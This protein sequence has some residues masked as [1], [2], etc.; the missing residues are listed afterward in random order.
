[1]AGPAILKPRE[2]IPTSR[3]RGHPAV[4]V[5]VTDLQ[6]TLAGQV[7]DILTPPSV[8]AFDRAVDEIGF[9]ELWRLLSG[10]PWAEPYITHFIALADQRFKNDRSLTAENLLANV[11]GSESL[12]PLGAGTV[13]VLDLNS[14]S[15]FQNHVSQTLRQNLDRH[16]Q[17]VFFA[18]G[19]EFGVSMLQM[20][21]GD[22][23]TFFLEE[24]ADPRMDTERLH[25]FLTR[26]EEI[27]VST[28]I[29]SA[30][31][32]R[33]GLDS[34]LYP[35]GNFTFA[36]GVQAVK[37]GEVVVGT[38]TGPQGSDQGYTAVLGQ[39]W[40]KALKLQ[41]GAGKGC[42]LMDEETVV[43]R[44]SAKGTFDVSVVN[45]KTLEPGV[46]EPYYRGIPL[47]LVHALHARGSLS[48][49]A[50]APQPDLG[51]TAI[52]I[53]M[54]S[55]ENLA[56][57][58]E[59][60]AEVARRILVLLHEPRFR[61]F[62]V[63]KQ[64]ATSLHVLSRKNPQESQNKN[65]IE[66][67]CTLA[68][69]AVQES[70][71]TVQVGVDYAKAMLE[72]AYK[73]CLVRDRASQAIVREARLSHAPGFKDGDILFGGD[74]LTAAGNRLERK[75]VIF[76]SQKGGPIQY[77]KISANT[78]G[79][80][81]GQT[82]IGVGPKCAQLADFVRGKS[83]NVVHL[84]ASGRGY[85]RSALLRYARNESP[86]KSFDFPGVGDG[87]LPHLRG[88]FMQLSLFEIGPNSPDEEVFEAFQ[89][90]LQGPDQW[91][92]DCL[93][94]L[95][96]EGLSH[97]EQDYLSRLAQVLPGTSI[98]FIHTGQITDGSVLELTPLNFE[99]AA[100]LVLEANREFP[101]L[102]AAV[103]EAALQEVCAKP[104]MAHFTLTPR[105]L[106]HAFAPALRMFGG[107]TEFLVS[108]I[109]STG[110]GELGARLRSDKLPPFARQILGILAHVRVPVHVEELW[111][112][113]GFATSGEGVD[114]SSF[115]EALKAL[116]PYLA[117]SEVEGYSVLSE[118]SNSAEE[119]FVP[120]NDEGLSQFLLKNI[121]RSDTRELPAEISE[122]GARTAEAELHHL[123]SLSFANSPYREHTARLVEKLGAF[124]LD[125]KMNTAARR[126][127][128]HYYVQWV[129]GAAE[130]SEK[131][132]QLYMDMA[133]TFLDTR[134]RELLEVV[135]EIYEQL[136]T[137]S[138]NDEQKLEIE[139]RR[140]RLLES[141]GP[142]FD[143]PITD[144]FSVVIASQLDTDAKKRMEW[145]AHLS[146]QHRPLIHK[147]R[148]FDA[149][150][151]PMAQMLLWTLAFSA[152][153]QKVVCFSE[154]PQF[155]G[156]R[157]QLLEEYKQLL[158]RRS[159]IPENL[160][161]FAHEMS[162]R[163]LHM[164]GRVERYLL[165]EID[166]EVPLQEEAKTVLSSIKRPEGNEMRRYGVLAV[167]ARG[168][169][170]Y[171][172]LEA[173]QSREMDGEILEF[174][175]NAMDFELE[176]AL[177]GDKNNRWRAILQQ[178]NAIDL[179][180]RAIAASPEEYE[181]D[182]TI[183]ELIERYMGLARIT[184]ALSSM[185]SLNYRVQ[186]LNQALEMLPENRF[187]V[188]KWTL[189][190]TA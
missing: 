72:T 96:R 167:Q 133:W 61:D 150:G 124:Y 55:L 15:T 73:D 36:T 7:G 94:I 141:K 131:D 20:P 22:Q 47:A 19:K 171:R 110:T 93:L 49:L 59:K 79:D 58:P 159:E 64:D 57:S 104:E 189:E 190:E 82:L 117:F 84:K 37:A 151:L 106:I 186:N 85:G 5:A 81:E 146:N 185:N 45:K 103:V 14:Y 25:A 170:V 175:R 188:R 71:L 187:T 1:M 127:Y 12:R 118:H 52:G 145:A 158:Q 155:N 138:L 113:Y 121:Y 143:E 137:M 160:G 99:E 120:E 90:L 62:Y 142:N 27:K 177:A 21:A 23:Y 83:G 42:L 184:D 109:K 3:R 107:R 165:D 162:A 180:I 95:D 30:E 102:S 17:D 44:Q 130:P 56:D 92:K 157:D 128:H 100:G 13:V 9:P 28:G 16:M 48:S 6:G 69:G 10:A 38:F 181:N 65:L 161:D 114:R 98:R 74:F 154:L 129:R 164:Q 116:S 173:S 168:L 148:T 50:E 178:M 43:R 67:F 134:D 140:F 63:L 126:L 139:W 182:A 76:P 91:M 172:R 53:R 183:F 144:D 105:N 77:L 122:S 115:E 97:Q 101:G 35:D 119:L 46:S 54:G 86:L 18:L 78:P 11:H 2:G 176:C 136:D 40:V 31:M 108:E 112:I 156:H 179:Y 125:R 89:K 166:K 147:V 111:Q 174:A 8:R 169:S 26:V 152:F 39:G 149:R 60:Y 153:F 29:S 87:N 135:Q 70:G 51:V 41:K 66:E 4:S 75:T 88:F 24:T 68:A 33:Y 80:L 34:A 132:I 123:F 163:A 32:R